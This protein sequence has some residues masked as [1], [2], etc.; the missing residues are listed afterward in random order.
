MDDLGYLDDPGD[1]LGMLDGQALPRGPGDRRHR[2]A[3]GAGDPAG[4][5]V[6][7]PP[8]RDAGPPSSAWSSC[9]QHCRME[10]EF[11]QFEVNRY[12]G[13]PGQAPSYKVGERIWLQAREEA[14]ARQGAAFD[15]KA[16]HRAGARP[17]L[18]RP[19]P[20]A[21]RR[22]PASRDPRW[23]WRRRRPPGWRPCAPPGIE[24]DGDRLRRRRVGGRRPA[25]PAEL[26][27]QLAEL[28][29]RPSPAA[30]TCP[31]GALVLGCDSVLE[32][33]GAALGKPA[34]ADEARSRWR[35]MRGRSGV[36]HTGHCA[37]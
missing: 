36:L 18:A 25:D 32:L 15:L 16:F 28:K 5:P 21:G 6:R 7:V 20:A 37:A 12:L 29:A 13:W 14:K 2:H 19:R 8:R 17:R 24:P 30:T 3:P 34:D 31:D 26:A 9:A 10:D 22:W 23:S 35:A 4:Q 27:L 1:K 33:D 11:I